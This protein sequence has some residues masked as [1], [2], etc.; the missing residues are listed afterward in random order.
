MTLT[1]D[2]N[3]VSLGSVCRVVPGY[4]FSSKDWCDDGIPVIKIKNIRADGFVDTDEVDHVPRDLLT[5]KLRKYLLEDGDMLLA[6]TGA[7]AGKVGKLRSKQP[8]LLNQRVARFEPFGI[9]ERF[10]WS[11]VSSADYQ[12]LFFRLAD[13]AAQPNMSG[14][15]I[16]GVR[17]PLP[18]ERDQRR[19][20]EILGAYDDLIDVNRRRVTLLE[21]MA[22][23]LFE[24]W[25]VR[26]RFPG[27]EGQQLLNTAYGP[28]PDGWAWQTLQDILVLQRGF[29][30]P[31]SARS[32]GPYQVISA[33]GPHGPHSAFKVQGPGV[34]TGRSGTIGKVH[35]VFA[36]HWPLNTTLYVKEFRQAGPAFATL[37]LRHLDLGK[38]STGAAVPTLNRNHVHGS[39]VPG[40]P[41]D[42][43]ARFEAFAMNCFKASDNFTQQNASLTASRDLLLPRLIS[44]QLSVAD[45]EHELAQAA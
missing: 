9:D 8:H 7:T 32:D 29:D 38:S 45:A 23:S 19:I 1:N 35:L 5:A 41:R 10:F 2:W 14:S 43:M 37:L 34:V 21:E 6:M 33:S 27:H 22:R 44:G 30:L 16:E 20:A 40:P 13:G 18:P 28:L 36:D 11:V 24:E 25:F 39:F 15:Q 17:L 26:F 3:E 4:A 31:S 42:L 12:T